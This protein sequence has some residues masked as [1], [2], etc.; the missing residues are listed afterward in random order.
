MPT[1]RGLGDQMKRVVVW[2]EAH[3]WEVSRC[4]NCHLRL[5][6]HCIKT[7]VFSSATPRC[8]HVEKNTISQ[9]RRLMRDAGI[10][11]KGE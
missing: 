7:V 4:A 11:K 6:H 1:L 3:G 2:A 5:T 10:T 8:P 9:M